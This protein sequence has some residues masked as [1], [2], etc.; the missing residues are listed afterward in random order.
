MAALAAL[1]L[2]TWRDLHSPPRYR[3]PR[4]GRLR[5]EGPSRKNPDYPLRSLIEIDQ[6]RCLLLVLKY[7]RGPDQIIEISDRNIVFRAS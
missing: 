3:H 6:N 2:N 4:S 5:T 1:K 7:L